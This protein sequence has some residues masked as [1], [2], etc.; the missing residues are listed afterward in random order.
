MRTTARSCAWCCRSCLRARQQSLLPQDKALDE[1]LA[2][3]Q[4]GTQS[5]AASAVNKLAVR[6]AAGSDRLAELVRQDQDL[7]S[8]SRGAGQG[9]H[10]G[11]VEAV[12]AARRRR[13]AAQPRA[14]RSD[15]KR[16]RRLAEDARRR[17]P[18]LCLALQPAAVDGEGHPAA[19]VGR[20]GDGALFRRRQARATSSRSRARA[21]TGRR[22]RLAPTRWR[23][24]SRL[25][26]EASMSARRAM[27]SG[28]SGLFDLALA[29]ELYVTL[30]GPVEALIKDKSSLLVVPSGALTALPFHLLVTE[31]PAGC[32]PGHARRLSQRRL[33]AAA[34]GRLGAAVGGQPEIAA[35]LCAQGSGRQADDRL[36]RSRVQSRRRRRR[37]IVAQQAA[38]L[39]RAASRPSPTPISGAAPASIARGLRRRCRNCP[40]PPTS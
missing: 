3:I 40:I 20:R 25:S 14:D 38:R 5:S 8:R 13:R 23:R 39:P 11:G 35:R 34:S 31:K 10:R 7:G 29:N 36:W 12:G 24:R 2:A 6:L 18:R 16:A 28:K 19:A 22:F 9:D 17:I 33:A 21:P 1:A 37:P 4:R 32:D 15:R 30:L 27:R 26:A